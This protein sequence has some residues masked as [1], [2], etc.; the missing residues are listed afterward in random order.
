MEIPAG[1][2]KWRSALSKKITAYLIISFLMLFLVL[3]FWLCVLM[4]SSAIVRSFTEPFAGNR[5][6]NIK[7]F[8]IS[9]PNRTIF[10]DYLESD[11]AQLEQTIK[12]KELRLSST[13]RSLMKDVFLIRYPQ[14]VYEIEFFEMQI[15]KTALEQ[16]E[17]NKF[18]LKENSGIV[19][20]SGKVSILVLPTK[21][22]RLE[23]IYALSSNDQSLVLTSE[24]Q[25]SLVKK[26]NS[27]LPK[28]IF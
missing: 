5:R 1:M 2:F 16:T 10:A 6:H 18:E 25:R 14:G 11:I 27:Y 4:S 12:I 22:L 13:S 26:I 8:Y 3:L 20:L 17:L 15:P 7:T 19:T 9:I 21:L 28:T 23:R 24:A